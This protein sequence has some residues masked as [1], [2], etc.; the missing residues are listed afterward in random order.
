M[1]KKNKFYQ[2]NITEITVLD[3][4]NSN[5]TFEKEKEWLDKMQSWFDDDKEFYNEKLIELKKKYNFKVQDTGEEKFE[6]IR[7]K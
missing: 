1:N 4:E 3:N 7:K 6:K 2:G 5:L